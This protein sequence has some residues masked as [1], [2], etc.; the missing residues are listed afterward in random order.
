MSRFRFL[1]CGGVVLVVSFIHTDALGQECGFE[2]FKILPSDGADGD[3]FGGSMALFWNDLVV[4]APEN[5]AAYLFNV[6][7]GTQSHKLTANDSGVSAFGWA[8]ASSGFNVYVGAPN[9]TNPAGTSTPGTA[10]MFT[11]FTGAKVLR[12]DPIDGGNIDLFGR[13]IGVSGG[14]VAVGS[15]RVGTDNFGAVY[16]FDRTSS[17]QT[18]KLLASN[19]LPDD[20]MGFS[21]DIDGSTLV[22]GAPRSQSDNTIAGAAFV[23]D[24]GSQNQVMSLFN[25]GTTGDRFGYS[26]AIGSGYILVGAPFDDTVTINSGAVYIFDASSGLLL[27][28]FLP[29]TVNHL[30][31]NERLG[32]S[33]TIEGTRALF[34]GPGVQDVVILYDL[35][36]ME[37]IAELRPSDPNDP[38]DLFFGASVAMNDSSIVVGATQDDDNGTNSGSVYRFDANPESCAADITNDC[39]LNFFDVSAFLTA[40][41][42]NDPIADFTGDGNYN[43]FDVSAFL[44]AFAVGCP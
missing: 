3:R 34:G 19:G 28:K 11:A 37:M 18:G 44:G 35:A 24:I 39:R 26:V 30:A 32:H 17:F 43:F 38:F 2:E 16:L 23:F 25:D 31:A 1:L 13:S 5:N 8:V 40:F 22:T 21:L 4:G 36:A 12:Y 14:T 33:V 42:S 29:P 27:E 20:R 7:D 6:L 9:S 10:F 41:S 15:P